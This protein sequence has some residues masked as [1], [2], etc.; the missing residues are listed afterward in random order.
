M[1]FTWGM[2]RI[3]KQKVTLFVVNSGKQQNLMPVSLSDS[4]QSVDG[5]HNLPV[6]AISWP[7]ITE[8]HFL[9]MPQL[10]PCRPWSLVPPVLL[11][12]RP[13][14]PLA[15]VSLRQ[16]QLQGAG[17]ACPKE[18]Q[19]YWGAPPFPTSI[20]TLVFTHFINSR[21]PFIFLTVL[22]PFFFFF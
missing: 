19:G 6:M 16:C 18:A 5:Q 22:L 10:S 1:R 4:G 2:F 8:Q 7:G 17:R 14:L 11:G 15:K 12:S 3:T 13:S 21:L 20:T 9:Q